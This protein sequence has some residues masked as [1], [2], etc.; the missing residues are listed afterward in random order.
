MDH[1]QDDSSNEKGCGASMLFTAHGSLRFEY[2]IHF[3]FWA[4]NNEAEYEAFLAVLRMARFLG[5]QNLLI[6]CDSQLM[7][8]KITKEYQAKD[9]KMEK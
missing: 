4:S 5:V 1:V 6:Y 7:V 9:S 8:N 2:A 3:N